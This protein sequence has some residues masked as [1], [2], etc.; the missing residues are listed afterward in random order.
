MVAAGPLNDHQG[1]GSIGTSVKRDVAVLRIGIL[2]GGILLWEAIAMSGLLYK[3]V[4]PSLVRIGGAVVSILFQGSHPLNLFGTEFYVP[5][6][7]RNLGVTAYEIGVALVIGGS[8]GLIVGWV[9]GVNRFLDQ[10]F[11]R[12]LYYLGPT[13]KIIFFPL[14]I[15]WFGVGPSSKIAM[16][17]IS[18]F[19][20]IA[21]SVTAGVRQVDRVLV[22]VGRSF[23]MTAWQMFTKIYVP[24][25]REPIFNGVRLGLGVAMVG[26]LLAET[27]L[28]KEG[29]GFMIINAYTTFDMPRMYGILILLFAIAIGL[30]A[31]INKIR[32]QW[33]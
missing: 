5:A 30:N 17:V 14:M 10:A 16:G 32:A 22:R 2:L 6:F 25:T 24:A 13:P 11:E 15:M 19:F 29:I 18:C 26:T 1:T 12:Y 3:D 21:L 9:L 7:Y 28:S 31:F 27:K 33:R 4:V 8:A 23:R 20:P